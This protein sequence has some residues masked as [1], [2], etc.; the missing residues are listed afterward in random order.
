MHEVG[1]RRSGLGL[2]IRGRNG[3]EGFLPRFG[4]GHFVR[5][6]EDDILRAELVHDADEEGLRAAGEDPEAE[7]R[8][9]DVIDGEAARSEFVFPEGTPQRALVDGRVDGHGRFS[10][11]CSLGRRPLQGK[12]TAKLRRQRGPRGG[13]RP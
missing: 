3:R 9:V 5:S 7:L 10:V 1:E 8:Q 11:V 4:G 13:S 12:G 6:A 2:G